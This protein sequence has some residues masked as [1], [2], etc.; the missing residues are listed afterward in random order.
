MFLGWFALGVALWT[1][2]EWFIHGRLGHRRGARNRFA[3]EHAKHHATPQYIAGWTLKFLIVT[4]VALVLWALVTPVLG[5]PDAAGLVAGLTLMYL[6]YE[7]VHR[8]IHRRPP[9]SRYGRWLRI[10][11]VHHHFHGPRTN[12]GVTS[13]IWDRVFGTY[14]RV[15]LPVSIPERHAPDWLLDPATGDVAAAFAGTYV[16]SR[17]RATGG[18]GTR[19]S[20]GRLSEDRFSGARVPE[21]RVSGA[22][23]SE[24][25][26]AG[27]QVPGIRVSEA[28]VSEVQVPETRVS[29]ARVSEARAS[30]ARASEARASEARA[31]GESRRGT[32]Q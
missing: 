13:P 10:H 27:A 18:S 11:H 19:A 30:E 4:P 2:L 7:L 26:A 5:R 3:V 12:L 23:A 20:E 1:L 28:Q 14:V 22:R 9:R 8:L 32:G 17:R 31:S 15:E 16:I 21:A 6:Y 25:R 29:G 24:V